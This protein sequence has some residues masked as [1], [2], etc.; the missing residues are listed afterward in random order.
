MHPAKWNEYQQLSGADK[1]RFFE[2]QVSRKISSSM[3]ANTSIECRQFQID[4][5]IAEKIMDDLLFVAEEDD[6]INQTLEAM[7]FDPIDDDADNISHYQATIPNY[8]QFLSVIKFVGAGLSFRQ[9]SQVMGDMKESLGLHQVGNVTR[10]K[11]TRFV[12]ICCTNSFQIISEAL[13]NVCVRF[14]LL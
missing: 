2:G 7:G 14:V 13:K 11:V 12:R 5:D 1:K 10:R 9:V 6:D 3:I 4:K 8:L